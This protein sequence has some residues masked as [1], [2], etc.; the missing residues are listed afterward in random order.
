MGWTEQ[1]VSPPY[2]LRPEDRRDPAAPWFL[3]SFWWFNPFYGGP[4]VGGPTYGETFGML[5]RQDMTLRSTLRAYRR[6]AP[7]ISEART[8][9]DAARFENGVVGRGLTE[10]AWAGRYFEGGLIYLP[11]Y[12]PPLNRGQSVIAP[13]AA[14]ADFPEQITRSIV[15]PA[16]ASPEAPPNPPALT[17]EEER[18]LNRLARDLEASWQ[19]QDIALLARR[20]EPNSRVTVAPTPQERYTLAVGDYLDA[21]RDAMRYTPITRFVAHSPQVVRPG[22]YR[23][24]AE[25]V[26]S[27]KANESRSVVLRYL[28]RR[29]GGKY[30][31]TGMETF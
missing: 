28:A 12:T 27:D 26:Y 20:L 3:T 21:T 15:R 29:I 13:Y 2:P 16:P 18:A 7:K 17:Q 8:E 25:L 6:Q 14:L 1:F 4:V 31:L 11:Y 10:S 22:I 30:Y 19:T 24:A 9:F 23:L 5:H